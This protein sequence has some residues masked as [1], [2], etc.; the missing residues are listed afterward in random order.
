MNK[1]K[2]IRLIIEDQEEVI[3]WDEDVTTD[4]LHELIMYITEDM[5]KLYKANE[6][7]FKTFAGNEIK[8]DTICTDNTTPVFIHTPDRSDVKTE[9]KVDSRRFKNLYIFTNKNMVRVQRFE[10]IRRFEEIL[11]SINEISTSNQESARLKF[12]DPP[13]QNKPKLKIEVVQP[14]AEHKEEKKHDN[15]KTPADKTTGLRVE[16]QAQHSHS[17]STSGGDSGTLKPNAGGAYRNDTGMKMVG[18]G[19]R[20]SE[21]T[22]R[23]SSVDPKGHHKEEPALKNYTMDEIKQHNTANDGWMVL[24]GKVYNVTKYLAYHPGGSVINQGLGKD[25]TVLFN[26]YHSWVNADH[27][28]KKYHI[29]SVKRF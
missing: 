27:I 28:L 5:R 13:K 2:I 22:E 15:V 4:Q 29:G 10:S 1:N 3:Y 18:H 16:S 17:A 19:S 8:L 21:S 11:L 9:H 7:S 6:L 25:A 20:P 12:D 23:R 14:Q 26:Q 24:N